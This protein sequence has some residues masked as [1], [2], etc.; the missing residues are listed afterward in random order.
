MCGFGGEVE[1]RPG[2]FS[3]SR[4]ARACTPRSQT[5]LPG[6]NRPASSSCS[7]ST[8]AL[9]S[10]SASQSELAVGLDFYDLLIEALILGSMSTVAPRAIYRSNGHH[11]TG[12]APNPMQLLKATRPV[13]RSLSLVSTTTSNTSSQIGTPFA[14]RRGPGPPA[15]TS[16]PGPPSREGHQHRQNDNDHPG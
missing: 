14:K 3:S 7:P 4:I 10:S 12:K 9:T 11:D 16:L 8:S 15:Q 13:R 2:F 1:C 6:D 5:F